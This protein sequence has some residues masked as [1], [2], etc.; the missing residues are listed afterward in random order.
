MKLFKKENGQAMVELALVLPILI[1]VFCGIIDFGWAYINKIS[2]NNAAREGARYASIHYHEAGWK[3]NCFTV[4]NESTGLINLKVS[5][6]VFDDTTKVGAVTV[7]IDTKAPVLTGVT[8]T[9]IGSTEFSLKAE[10]TMR[11]E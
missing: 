9:I 5:E 8:S 2:V 4:V 10:S 11:I 6:V 7:K 1:L 3:T